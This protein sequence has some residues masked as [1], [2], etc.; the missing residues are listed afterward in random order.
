MYSFF[1]FTFT[2][3]SWQILHLSVP[4]RAEGKK[5]EPYLNNLPTPSNSITFFLFSSQISED[6]LVGGGAG[7]S[8]LNEGLQA[9]GAKRGKMHFFHLAPL[10][11]L[12]T[13]RGA[14]RGRRLVQRN[15]RRLLRAKLLAGEK[16]Q[17]EPKK[18]RSPEPTTTCD[19]RPC[20][21]GRGRSRGRT[22]RGPPTKTRD[23]D[24]KPRLCSF[25]KGGS[26]NFPL[27][28]LQIFFTAGLSARLVGRLDRSVRRAS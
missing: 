13:R 6:L 24:V 9:W 28:G 3:L 23:R 7:G 1:F 12:P 18:R 2:L 27:Q 10:Q 14:S 22:R 19:V 15:S 20:V 17:T 11:H 5:G 26:E 25:E 8:D 16:H 21:R 4:L